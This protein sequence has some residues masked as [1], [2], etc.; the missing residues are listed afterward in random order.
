MRSVVV[1][2][3]RP[4]SWGRFLEDLAAVPNRSRGVAGIPRGCFWKVL[5][6][7]I[8]GR[9]E[10][11]LFLWGMLLEHPRPTAVLSQ[12]EGMFFEGPAAVPIYR[13]LGTT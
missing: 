5:P 11:P 10:M 4:S 3:N 2:G 8:I 6:Q 12:V 1:E 7:Y 9:G 13:S